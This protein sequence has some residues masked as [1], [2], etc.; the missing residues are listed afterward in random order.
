MVLLVFGRIC[1]ICGRAGCTGD[2][3]AGGN[4]CCALQGRPGSRGHALLRVVCRA[5]WVGLNVPCPEIAGV[6]PEAGE[7]VSEGGCLL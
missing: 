7:H 3:V 4:Q 1:V 6:V 5:V 2:L